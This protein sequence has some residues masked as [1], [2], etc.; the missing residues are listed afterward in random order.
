M[1]NKDAGTKKV[2]IGFYALF[3]VANI[4]ADAFSHV[5]L[6]MVT[7]PFLMVWLSL[8]FHVATKHRPSRFSRFILFG[9]LFS[10]A[11]DTFLMLVDNPP[12][13]PSF[14]LLGLGSFLLAHL[15][16]LTAFLRYSDG[17]GLIRKKP[18]LVLP[19][20]VFWISINWVMWEGV[21][22]GMKLPVV[23][24]SLAISAM[25]VGC[26]NLRELM[27]ARAWQVLFVGV[28]CFLFSDTIIG[29]NKFYYMGTMP[30]A[31]FLI[32]AP[33]LLG[34]FLIAQGAIAANA[35]AKKG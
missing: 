35:T 15:C 29:I 6:G 22:S 1:D 12:H 18:L 8:Y 21:P 27:P 3:S 16:Y 31:R 34:Q 19:F 26:L 13:I 9:F 5:M 24:Y 25:A 20:I 17:I 30:Y 4:L 28:L 10:I 2:L 23:V 32:M 14:F 33:Y 7:K 11:G